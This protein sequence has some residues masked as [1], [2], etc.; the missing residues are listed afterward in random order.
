[1]FWFAHESVHADIRRYLNAATDDIVASKE[2]VAQNGNISAV[3]NGVAIINVH[4][5]LLPES[6]ALLSFFGVTH[7]GYNDIG[8]AISA[9]NDDDSVSSITLNIDSGGG[10]IKGLS[11]LIDVMRTSDKPINADIY[12]ICA[13]AAYWI[14]SQ[15]D[16]IKV[17]GRASMVGSV[18]VAVDMFVFDQEISIA[19]TDSP[20][21]RPDVRTEEG[22][23][24]VQKELD[25]LASLFFSDVADGRNT[26]VERVKADFGKGGMLLPEEAKRVG[27]VD[28][29]ELSTA[30]RQS[31]SGN[32]N[33]NDD[34]VNTMDINKLKAD[35]PDVYAQAVQV[36]V[37]KE[38]DRVTAHLVLADKCSA[39]DIA[40]EAIQAGSGMT[41]TL[42]AKY[43]TAG[44]S[45]RDTEM[46]A[47]EDN[48][49]DTTVAAD[50]AA[51]V[52][53]QVMDA[54]TG[55]KK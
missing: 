51:S 49:L 41:D 36:G 48:A 53:D 33:N 16:A 52:E 22:R 54:L 50:V 42:Q 35:H 26:T 38:R 1:M 21:K 37:D 25:Q 27:M 15:A 23:M 29:V 47:G 55:G 6:S 45:K 30:A 4:G 5:V 18:G 34:E 12:S 44:M 3:T 39:F 14:A 11:E 31:G 8:S 10:S 46:R 2:F 7:T 9:A 43:L 40:S 13:S 32:N 17:Y 28:S 20:E 24:M 19:N